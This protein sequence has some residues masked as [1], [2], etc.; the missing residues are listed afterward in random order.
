MAYDF[1]CV[2][3]NAVWIIIKSLSLSWLNTQVKDP[4]LRYIV[5]KRCRNYTAVIILILFNVDYLAIVFWLF[6]LID[7]FI[8]SLWLLFYFGLS[9][10]IFVL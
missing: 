6:F 7:V 3:V 1:D 10:S 4:V 2:M 5:A 8:S 9:I